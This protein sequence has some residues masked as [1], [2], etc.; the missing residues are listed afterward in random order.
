MIYYLVI[1]LIYSI[2]S[3]C[4]KNILQMDPQKTATSSYASIYTTKALPVGL[5]NLN[6][7]APQELLQANMHFTDK[8]YQELDNLSATWC[9]D[10]LYKLL[11]QLYTNNL[12]MPE[13]FR[14]IVAFTK[15]HYAG[16]YD[17]LSQ[18]LEEM[19]NKGLLT[20]KHFTGLMDMFIHMTDD[21]FIPS[22]HLIFERL[23]KKNLLNQNNFLEF[24]LCREYVLLGQNMLYY[25]F[26][27]L[28]VLDEHAYLDIGSLNKILLMP[29][30]INVTNFISLDA[31]ISYLLRKHKDLF[32]KTHFELL[33]KQISSIGKH[34]NRFND[35]YSQDA[36]IDRYLTVLKKIPDILLYLDLYTQDIFQEAIADGIK[37][38]EW[39]WQQ[40]GNLPRWL[41]D[42]EDNASNDSSYNDSYLILRNII[43]QL[44]NSAISITP[45]TFS[46]LLALDDGELN[47]VH[48]I[49]NIYPLLR[50]AEFLKFVYNK[51]FR[52]LNAK[53]ICDII[54]MYPDD[55]QNTV[56]LL[57]S[58]SGSELFQLRT[59][60][61]TF[62]NAGVPCTGNIIE[63]FCAAKRH[64]SNSKSFKKQF[65]N[66]H[67]LRTI[68][69]ICA[70][71]N[72]LINGRNIAAM[73]SCQD[74]R[75]AIKV[76][77]ILSSYCSIS[78]GMFFNEF[79]QKPDIQDHGN[80]TMLN[81][82]RNI[83]KQLDKAG[84]LK[85]NL[86]LIKL[87][88]LQKCNYL[89]HIDEDL[90][91]LESLTQN[92]VEKILRK[93]PQC[94]YPHSCSVL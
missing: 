80:T 53:E 12:L 60:L 84:L 68:V 64:Y 89:R 50:N 78:D 42:D 9:N 83:V 85:D 81:T 47:V 7:S 94:Q 1:I 63:Q 44:R 75:T 66:K 25:L 76:W 74:L 35:F 72:L 82:F 57:L 40:Q 43:V 91:N 61:Q 21:E 36:Q 93:Y 8:D 51:P 46:K 48:D 22:H 69:G 30:I 10:T 70:K 34:L 33:L 39:R 17:L 27:L 49:I 55:Y 52:Y 16:T 19:D 92:Q 29:K 41:W 24:V 59:T 62:V 2:V 23:L 73:Q 15:D 28:S 65:N 4:G 58:L 6:S 67:M 86:S 88:V 11:K 54:N 20:Q 38:W 79:M 18:I 3:S 14:Q 45:D 71:N 56:K 32:T 90:Q 13:N 5:V 37:T 31:I 26:D 77:G 87:I